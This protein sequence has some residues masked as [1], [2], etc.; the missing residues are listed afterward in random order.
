MIAAAAVY[1]LSLWLTWSLGNDGLWLSFV[2]FLAL[3]AMFQLMLVPRLLRQE[4]GSD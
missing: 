4:F 1:A 2:L 3:R